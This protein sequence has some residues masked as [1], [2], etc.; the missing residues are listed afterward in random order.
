M[1]SWSR[2][3]NE[4]GR[5]A[6]RKIN[7]ITCRGSA[8]IQA[9]RCYVNTSSSQHD[10]TTLVN[11][12][13]VTQSPVTERYMS[14]AYIGPHKWF[15]GQKNGAADTN[16]TRNFSPS[17]TGRR[18]ITDRTDRPRGSTRVPLELQWT[19]VFR[20]LTVRFTNVSIQFD[21]PLTWQ[22]WVIICYGV[23]CGKFNNYRTIVVLL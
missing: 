11:D 13:I 4:S 3:N 6:D 23:F 2:V 15:A 9:W 17:I 7:S 18:D 10:V 12:V 5:I 22:A 16:A 21:S 8:F 20:S 1:C 14:T 19:H